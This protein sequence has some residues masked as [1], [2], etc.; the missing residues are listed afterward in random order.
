MASDDSSKRKTRELA[1]KLVYAALKFLKES[2]GEKRG[3]EVMDAVEKR[4]SLTDW[5]KE[6]FEKTGYIRWRS[7]LHFYTIDLVKAGF[8]IKKKGVWFL[9]PDGDEAIKL[10]ETGLLDAAVKA[11]REWRLKNP[12]QTEIIESESAVE[13]SAK[14]EEVSVDEIVQSA[15]EQIENYISKKNPYEFQDLAA[16][17]LRGMG[18]FTPFVAPA[19]KGGGVDIVAYRD[20]LGTSSPR[21]KLQIKHR[22]STATVQEVRQLMGLLQKDGDVGIFI[23]SGGFSPDAKTAAR[24]SNVH[25]E[26]VDLQRFVSLWQ[27]FYPK[28]NDEDKAKLPLMPIYI[29]ASVN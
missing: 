2:G 26:L 9:T 11:Y 15:Y 29:L 18:Y 17:L 27:E 6:R 4:V 28:L 16:A 25:V 22:G 1:A 12:K 8:L 5:E 7:V 23:S 10:G 21:I 13:E 3:R 20:P 24:N 19:G 14:E